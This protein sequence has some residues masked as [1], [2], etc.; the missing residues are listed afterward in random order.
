MRGPP[1]QLQRVCVGQSLLQQ[2]QHQINISWDPL[3]CRLQNGAAIASYIIQ[4][5]RLPYDIPRNISSSDS[6][7]ECHQVAGGPY[8]CLADESLFI[9]IGIPGEIYSF[10]VVAQNIHGV[11]SIQ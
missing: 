1:S 10:Q 3:L 11:G 7:L 4:Y 9:A 2:L 5:I 6:R 8:S